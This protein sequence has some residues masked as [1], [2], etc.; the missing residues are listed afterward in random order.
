MSL[1]WDMDLGRKLGEWREAQAVR[2][3]LE[4]GLADA[5]RGV[6]VEVET[7]YREMIDA[8]TMA[9]SQQKALKS[10]TDWVESQLV[11][12]ENDKTQLR[13]VLSGLLSF[14]VTRIEARKAIY[15]LDVAMAA[16]E[17]ASG[18]NLIPL[19]TLSGQR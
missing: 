13:D 12:Y 11:G 2:H 4:A 9:D 18:M 6:R 15:D 1:R 14:L 17:R 3:N 8:R 19:A 10:A 7:L 16:L 5:E